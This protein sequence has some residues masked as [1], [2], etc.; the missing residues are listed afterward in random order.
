MQ[1]MSRRK[2]EEEEFILLYSVTDFILKLIP[3]QIRHIKPDHAYA[4]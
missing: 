4:C 3:G 1:L 2:K